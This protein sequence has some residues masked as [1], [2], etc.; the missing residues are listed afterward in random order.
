MREKEG[1]GER[2]REVEPHTAVEM[3]KERRTCRGGKKDRKYNDLGSW[4]NGSAILRRQ[5]KAVV[6]QVVQP[7]MPIAQYN[8]L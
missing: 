1:E 3:S 8:E 4:L 5:V 7:L 2:E 6:L